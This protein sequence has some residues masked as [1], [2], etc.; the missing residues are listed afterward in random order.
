MYMADF[1]MDINN[2]L[3]SDKE[4]NKTK[5]MYS[6]ARKADHEASPIQN[7]VGLILFGGLCIYVIMKLV[8]NKR[9]HKLLDFTKNQEISKLLI[10]LLLLT[11]VKNLSNSLV[12]NI[13]LP[14]VEPA[15]PFLLCGLKISYG[16][17][18]IELGKLISDLLVFTINLSIIYFI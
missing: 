13:I 1:M 12:N 10:G 17:M 3:P 18:N 4:E 8:N 11:N 16:N 6:C 5:F 2:R 15:L 14:I 7:A 9:K